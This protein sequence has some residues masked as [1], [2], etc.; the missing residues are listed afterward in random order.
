M[1]VYFEWGDG[2]H[3]GWVGILTNG[4]VGN[5]KTWDTAGTYQVRV[6]ARDTPYLSESSWSDSLTVIISEEVNNPPNKPATPSGK[7][8]GKVNVSYTYGS[9]TMDSDGDQ[10]FYLFDWGDGTD[11]GWIGA[12]DSGDVCQESH[13]WTTKGSYSIKVKAKDTSGAESVWSDSLPITMPYSYD[14]QTLQFLE[15]LCERFPNTFPI[16]RHLL[17]Y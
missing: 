4:T 2:T 6:K 11:S 13:I 15:L 14:K 9:S 12:Y 3:T 16:L 5:Y 7:A 8:S 10:I 1:E 17:E